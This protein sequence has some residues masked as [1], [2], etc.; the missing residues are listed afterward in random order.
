MTRAANRYTTPQKLRQSLHSLNHKSGKS[1]HHKSWEKS[2][3][4]LQEQQPDTQ[5]A[6]NKYM[7]ATNHL[8]QAN[9]IDDIVKPALT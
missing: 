4:L 3:P 5:R 2:K 8:Y 1:I 7:Q 9:H 6:E